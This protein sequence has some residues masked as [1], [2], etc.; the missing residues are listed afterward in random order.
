MI[1]TNAKV[2]AELAKYGMTYTALAE[3]MGLTKQEL[4]IAIN[5]VEWSAKQQG[6][7]IRLIRESA[8]KGAV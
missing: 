4:S 2:R 7:A 5:S 1:T 8:G 6:E 3:L